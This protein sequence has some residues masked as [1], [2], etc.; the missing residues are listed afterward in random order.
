M[1][2]IITKFSHLDRLY[3]VKNKVVTDE[4]V[5]KLVEEIR[6]LSQD[7]HPVNS[8][9]YKD[10]T[11]RLRICITSETGVVIPLLKPV[12]ECLSSEHY[13]ASY[14]KIEYSNDKKA[15]GIVS[16]N[17]N[18]SAKHAFF[19]RD[20]AEFL[21]QHDSQ[22]NPTDDEVLFPKLLQMTD[23]IFKKHLSIV[24]SHVGRYF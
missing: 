3:D 22:H 1:Q 7:Q 24:I 18:L 15:S 4:M 21:I 13:L 10:V 8:K 5:K 19:L 12:V 20:C 16:G 23:V 9:K 2:V 6:S 14:I 17:Q 11:R